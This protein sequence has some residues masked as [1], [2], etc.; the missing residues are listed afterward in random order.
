MGKSNAD[1]QREYERLMEQF[2]EK[3]NAAVS[4]YAGDFKLQVELNDFIPLV[5]RL[6]EKFDMMIFSLHVENGKYSMTAAPSC[7]IRSFDNTPS[8]KV[9]RLHYLLDHTLWPNPE[10]IVAF[11]EGYNASRKT[12]Y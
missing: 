11:V 3:Y 8:S 2:T 12:C 4:K 7:D 9:G 10:V 1:I 6:T 5:K